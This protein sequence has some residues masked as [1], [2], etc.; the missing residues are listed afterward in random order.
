MKKVIVI[1]GGVSGCA[2]AV[3]AAS[4]GAQVT[5]LCKDTF[6][7]GVAVTGDH[8]TICGLSTINSPNPTLLEPELTNKWVDLLAVG[9]P[10]REGKVW[11]WP[12]TS[13]QLQDGL[14]QRLEETGV[15]FLLKK[16][17][18]KVILNEATKRIVGVT[19][20]SQ[21]FDC[22]I[23]IDTSNFVASYLGQKISK[24]VA[25]PAWRC[26]VEL[27]FSVDKQF[28][29]S[30]LLAIRKKWIEN[31]PKHLLKSSAL[32]L[33]IV[34]D[35]PSKNCWQ[36]SVDVPPKTKI[37]FIKKEVEEA[38]SSIGG[39]LLSYSKQLS[40]RDCGNPISSYNLEQLFSEKERGLCWASWP[41]E[42]HTETGVRW[43]WPD[44]DYHGVPLKA[45]RLENGPN[46]FYLIGKGMAVDSE[47]IAA[48]RVIGTSL[49]I[50]TSLGSQVLELDCE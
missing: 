35:I 47:A 48:L 15:H 46:N 36:L 1:G 38:L 11:L 42:L 14:K 49:A 23:C 24:L 20:D 26:I 3:A 27:P 28:R 34:F 19:A 45:C 8:R 6:L 18:D 30:T 37:C 40:E 9:A 22:D 31:D 5:L 39:T 4:T 10:Y 2:V 21:T 29:V 32:N 41:S 17:V 50:G 16:K 44:K 25:W 33:T 43:K 13:A 7:G 12:T